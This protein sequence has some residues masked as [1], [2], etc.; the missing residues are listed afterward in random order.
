MSDTAKH[1][2][3]VRQFADTPCFPDILSHRPLRVVLDVRLFCFNLCLQLR[4][5]GV[6]H[7]P[8]AQRAVAERLARH[9][10]NR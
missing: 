4:S 10:R 5:L 8:K 9:C 2:L 3:R 7:E 6:L 1:S